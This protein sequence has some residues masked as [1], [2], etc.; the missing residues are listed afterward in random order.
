MASELPISQIIKIGKICQYLSLNSV[1]SNN[2]NKGK[3]LDERAA[4]M[5][6][7]EGKSIQLRFLQNPSDTTLRNTSNY[8]YALLGRW[9]IEA[10]NILNNLAV[11]LPIV[12]GPSNQSTTVGGSATF[13][14]IVISAAPYTVQWYDMNN[15][16]IA[17]ATS[18]SYVFTN[19]QLTNNGNTFYLKATNSAG[20]TLSVVA[21]LTVTAPL[22]GFFSFNATNDYYPILL[23]SS[24][25]FAYQTTFPITHNSPIAFTMPAAMP[26]NQFMLV[27]V[28]IG[29]SVKATWFN[30]P[31]NNGTIPDTAFET[32]VQFGGFT[33]YA[34]RGQISMDVTQTLQLS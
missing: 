21:T 2:L 13:S 9:A 16:P 34:S 31:L 12:S 25:P 6:Y 29:E 19:A 4:R 8:F 11:A 1:S 26:A 27:K 14:T 22:F 10:Q 17:G 32:I 30:T 28:P 15:N 7:V 18:T 24:D 5:I 33:Y 20:T 23:T 3:A